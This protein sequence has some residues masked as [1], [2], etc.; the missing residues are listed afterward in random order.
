MIPFCPECKYWQT[1]REE[2]ITVSELLSALDWDG[3]YLFI[4]GS[5]EDDY[6]GASSLFHV[7]M[8]RDLAIK[9]FGSARVF[10]AELYNIGAVH[11]CDRDHFISWAKE[12]G[13]QSWE[14]LKLKYAEYKQLFPNMCLSG[15][16]RLRISV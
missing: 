13:A 2:T 11:A 14:D 12:N 16:S 15:Q 7:A 9:F 3:T 6:F 10:S 5:Q 1:K 4:T 8:R